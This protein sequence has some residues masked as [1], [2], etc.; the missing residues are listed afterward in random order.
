MQTKLT[1]EDIMNGWTEETLDV[2]L[3]ERQS[4]K[5][6]YAMAQDKLNT[7]VPSVTTKTFNPH[8]W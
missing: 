3:K 8:Q 7:N 5:S 1:R 2:Y 6:A 4:Q